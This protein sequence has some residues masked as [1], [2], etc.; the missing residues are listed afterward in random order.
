MS[1]LPGATSRLEVCSEVPQPDKSTAS[2]APKTARRMIL[3]LP[4]LAIGRQCAWNLF[5]FG[6]DAGTR[7]R[8]GLLPRDFKSLASTIPPR[9]RVDLRSHHAAGEPTRRL[10]YA[11]RL[12]T[13]PSS[14]PSP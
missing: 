10:R 1:Y 7:T 2:P 8:T 5:I 4:V 3:R 13:C 6:A 12:I 11:S 9:P 14:H